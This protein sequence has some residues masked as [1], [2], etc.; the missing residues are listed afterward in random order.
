MNF[1]LE[2]SVLNT[3]PWNLILSWTEVYFYLNI[4]IIF[5]NMLCL[6]LKI[7]SEKYFT[8]WYS[9]SKWTV[10]DW[11][12]CKENV[13]R[14]Q[15]DSWRHIFTT[16]NIGR[17]WTNL[18]WHRILV[19]W[20]IENNYFWYPTTSIWIRKTEINSFVILTSLTFNNLM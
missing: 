14:M 1:R 15:A 10:W 16:P 3:V 5:Y 7:I 17:D 2:N 9:N 19:S 18:H 8:W 20:R 6:L 13:D 4:Y 11:L 12:S